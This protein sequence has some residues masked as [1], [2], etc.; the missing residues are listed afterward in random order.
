MALYPLPLLMIVTAPKQCNAFPYTLVR[1][2]L[3]L[4]H[5]KATLRF[6]YW[7]THLL[8][9]HSSG[10]LAEHKS[11]LSILDT[12]QFLIIPMSSE[13]GWLLSTYVQLLRQQQQLE[14]HKK[15]NYFLYMPMQL[16][17]LKCKDYFLGQQE[18][19][20]KAQSQSRGTLSRN[21]LN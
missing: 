16:C 3:C 10:R 11:L 17:A 4:V 2:D 8:G 21:A 20:K 12:F 9:R 14:K 1:K 19:R 5:T 18:T 7:D 13:K 6:Y 15:A